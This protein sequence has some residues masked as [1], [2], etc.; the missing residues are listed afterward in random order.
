MAQVVI[1]SNDPT[2]E[3]S[4]VELAAGAVPGLEIYPDPLDF[5][6][7]YIGCEK[8][9]VVEL[10]NVG[11]DPLI[12]DEIVWTAD[13]RFRM[14]EETLPALPLTLGPQEQ[15]QIW[16]S[17]NPTDA[18]FASGELAVTSNEPM[19][20]RFSEMVGSGK[21]ADEQMDLWKFPAIPLGYSV[22]SGPKLFDGRRSVDVGKQLRHLH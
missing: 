19:G 18:P 3:Y 20:I 2:E 17:F 14:W 11:T 13:E 4:V 6:E 8:D 9:D 1:T 16:F 15:A 10:T 12:I 5:S 22:R 21:Y 7:A